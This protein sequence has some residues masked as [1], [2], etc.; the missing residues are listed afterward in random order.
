MDSLFVT[1]IITLIS[2]AIE[3]VLGLALAL[4]MHRT[5]FGRA[6]CAPRS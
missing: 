4:V 5:I 6:R 2:V 3:F 1:L